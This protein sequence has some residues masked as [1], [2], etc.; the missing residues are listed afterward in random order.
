MALHDELGRC[1]DICRHIDRGQSGIQGE[2]SEQGFCCLRP[3]VLEKF[4]QS[5][6]SHLDSDTPPS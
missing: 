2:M 6:F 5:P 3:F 4:S 1:K